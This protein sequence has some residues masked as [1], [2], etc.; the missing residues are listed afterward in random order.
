VVNAVAPLLRRPRGFTLIE[1]TVVVALIGLL[2]TLAVPRYFAS[3]EHGKR[4]VQ[5]QNLATIRDA[6]DK[7]YGDQS[8]YPES[9]EE[10]VT[11]HYLRAMPIDPVTGKSDWVVLPPPEHAA[12]V[13]PD[14]SLAAPATDTAPLGAVYDVKSNAGAPPA[15]TP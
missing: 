4:S 10:L 12:L 5:L 9:V 11:R 2:L 8:R 7:F 3:I 13:V 15:G 6:I 14:A 1:M